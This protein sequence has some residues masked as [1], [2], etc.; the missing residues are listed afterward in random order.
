MTFC[1]EAVGA[2]VNSSNKTRVAADDTVI[3]KTKQLSHPCL[4][5]FAEH[6]LGARLSIYF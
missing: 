4:P 5:S 3:G 6:S 1:I 2:M